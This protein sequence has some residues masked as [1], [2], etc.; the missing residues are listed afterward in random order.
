M[1]GLSPKGWRALLAGA[2]FLAVAGCKHDPSSGSAPASSSGASGD[3]GHTACGSNYFIDAKAPADCAQGANCTVAL[4]LV[5]TGEFHIND[6]YPYKFK[7]DDVPQVAFQGN[8]PAGNKFFSKQ[9][10]NWTKTA[11][12][13]GTMNVVFQ[14]TDKGK[15]NISG[16]FKLSVCSEHNCQ[17]EQTTVASNVDVH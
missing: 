7:A 14:S 13:K 17:L 16:V 10:N 6:D 12:Q 1:R 2:F 11:A 3:C 15:K 9:A 5:A 4:T 8:D